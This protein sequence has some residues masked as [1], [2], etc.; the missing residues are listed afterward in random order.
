MTPAQ[1]QGTVYAKEKK[2]I[3][4]KLIDLIKSVGWLT[5]Y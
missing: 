1:T 4:L 3:Q 5:D 2:N